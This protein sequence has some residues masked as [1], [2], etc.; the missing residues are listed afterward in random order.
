MIQE[1]FEYRKRISNLGI[2][3]DSPQEVE[4]EQ[5]RILHADH[6]YKLCAY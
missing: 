6:N 1:K 2:S 5:A 4:N 3:L